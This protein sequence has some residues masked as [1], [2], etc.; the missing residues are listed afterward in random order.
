MK[1]VLCGGTVLREQHPSPVGLMVGN[2]DNT[3]LHTVYDTVVDFLKR[4]K[5]GEG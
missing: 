5:V 3:A 2:A 1:N 4:S